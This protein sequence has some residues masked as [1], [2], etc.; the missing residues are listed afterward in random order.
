M[1][2]Q[3]HSH[4]KYRMS[5]LL[6]D[7]P[8]SASF[9]VSVTT[10]QHQN[11]SKAEVYGCMCVRASLNGS[12]LYEILSIG[13]PCYHNNTL[14]RVGFVC[15]IVDEKFNMCDLSGAV[16]ISE[17]KLQCPIS[18]LCMVLSRRAIIKS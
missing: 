5:H 18:F 6:S 12:Y 1:H 13:L 17:Y 3:L 16:Y 4:R 7:F 8:Q 10:N 14:C 11:F 2:A 15:I 9:C